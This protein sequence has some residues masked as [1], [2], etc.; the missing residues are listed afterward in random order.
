MLRNT[1]SSAIAFGADGKL[2]GREVGA[3]LAS[4]GNAV[5]A[6]IVA[7]CLANPAGEGLS[8]AGEAHGKEDGVQVEVHR[9]RKLT[10]VCLD[11]LWID[12]LD[13]DLFVTMLR[14]ASQALL[15]YLEGPLSA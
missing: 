13:E 15:I 12:V 6:S 1:D 4:V 9:E 11:G 7:G 5:G 8:A 2:G 3:A 10:K 14:R